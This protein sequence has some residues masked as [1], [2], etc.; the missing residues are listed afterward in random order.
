[1]T[2][3]LFHRV[4]AGLLAALGLQ[5]IEDPR[6]FTSFGRGR[7][8]MLHGREAIMPRTWSARRPQAQELN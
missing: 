5:R 2:R 7:L 1:M 6:S 4:A 3:R 8:V